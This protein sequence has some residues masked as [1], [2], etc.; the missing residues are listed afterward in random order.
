MNIIR[1]GK[2]DLIIP[3]FIY[4]L[5]LENYAIKDSK[6]NDTFDVLMISIFYNFGS[7]F[8][9]VFEIIIKYRVNQ[10]NITRSISIKQSY[11]PLKKGTQTDYK[12]IILY[13][14]ITLLDSSSSFFFFY[15]KNYF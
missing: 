6:I 13:S 10:K 2:I 4:F 1:F 5:F 12:I 7:I 9:I 14:I 15:G 3:I 11:I 8:G